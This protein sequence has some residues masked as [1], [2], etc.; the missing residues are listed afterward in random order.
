MKSYLSFSRLVPVIALAIAIFS[1]IQKVR[2]PDGT[3]DTKYLA[4]LLLAAIS[5]ITTIL[6]SHYEHSQTVRKLLDT[7]LP[8]FREELRNIGQGVGRIRLLRSVEEYYAALKKAISGASGRVDLLYLTPSPPDALGL[9]ATEYWKWFRTFAQNNGANIE[10][11]RIASLDNDAKRAWVLRSAK[12][13][14]AV[15]MYAL[16]CYDPFVSGTLPLLA[17]EVVDRSEV[18]ISGPHNPLVRLHVANPEFAKAMG[19]Y[20]DQI[21]AAVG[22]DLELKSLNSPRLDAVVEAKIRTLSL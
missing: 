9:P 13:V 8:G 11:R 20:F 14:E 2:N 17:V 22:D 4:L 19:E 6:F 15:P 5:G 1:A 3:A 18:F 12:D 16:R 21:W 7:E 10:I